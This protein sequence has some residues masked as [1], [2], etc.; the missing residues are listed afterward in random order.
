MNELEE[1]ISALEDLVERMAYHLHEV[2]SP[3]A[4]H[5]IDLQLAEW[6][7]RIASYIE[8]ANDN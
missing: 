4:Q 1:R 2:A 3:H 7:G 8:V 5:M 6:E